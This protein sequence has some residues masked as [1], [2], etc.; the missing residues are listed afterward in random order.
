M[1]RRFAGLLGALALVVCLRV[2]PVGACLVL[3]DP[4]VAVLERVALEPVD[5]GGEPPASLPVDAR[6]EYGHD[7][8]ASRL[9][10]GDRAIA[11]EVD[12]P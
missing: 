6:L 3:C 7:G 5:G 11:L 1:I 12:L 9:L 8:R 10:L 2:E 4:P